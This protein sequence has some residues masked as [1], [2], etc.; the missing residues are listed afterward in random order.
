M[1]LKNVEMKLIV[2]LQKFDTNKN[3]IVTLMF[4]A[5]Y[6][7]LLN[8]IQVMQ[9]INNDI[10]LKFSRLPNKDIINL[11]YYRFEKAIIGNDG[12]SKL[13]FKGVVESVNSGYAKLENI[14]KMQTSE[15]HIDEFPLYISAEVELEDDDGW[16]DEVEQIDSNEEEPTKD[17][18]DEI[19]EWDEL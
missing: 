16:D 4:S 15:S 12:T 10:N 19:D 17:E 1:S 2:E 3:D 18:W 13:T 6:D 7:E 5:S 14:I 9:L 11:G 8:V